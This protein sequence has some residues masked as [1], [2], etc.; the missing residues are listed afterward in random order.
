M[1]KGG[2]GISV[3][4]FGMYEEQEWELEERGRRGGRWRGR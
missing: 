1:W 4:L 3:K 2:E